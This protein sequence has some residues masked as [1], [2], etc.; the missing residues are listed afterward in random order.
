MGLEGGF[1]RISGG[2]NTN[3]YFLSTILTNPFVDSFVFSPSIMHTFAGSG[4]VAGDSGWSDSLSYSIP[5]GG[6]FS[7]TAIYAF[8]EVEGESEGKVG[9]NV[10]Y[11][12]GGLVATAAVTVVDYAADTGDAADVGDSQTAVLLGATY[13]FGVATLSAQ[14]QN[15]SDDQGVGDL[16]TYILGAAIPAG[17]GSVLAA[18]AFTDYDDFDERLTV[19]VGYNYAVTSAFDTYVAFMYDDDDYLDDDGYVFGV[20]GR[21]RF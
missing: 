21:Y 14:F 10:F 17:P 3:P 5:G 4:Y 9:G 16:N 6:G 1:G 20:G 11:R 15:I 18:V 7:A 13:D 12:S 19:T 8:G 2:R